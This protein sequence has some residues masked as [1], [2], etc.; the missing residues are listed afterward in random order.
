[1]HTTSRSLTLLGLSAFLA[2]GL[3]ATAQTKDIPVETVPASGPKDKTVAPAAA[4]EDMIVLSQFTVQGDKTNDY[5]AS[6]SVTGTRVASK[7]RD[8]P[9][10]VNVVTAEFMTDFGAF[11]MSQQLGWVSN[12]SPSDTQGNLVLRGFT[13][14]PFVDGF[15]RLGNLDIVDTARVEII[16]G[17]AASIYGQ[18]LPGGVVNYVSKTPSATHKDKIDLTVGSDNFFRASVSSTGPVGNSKKLFYLAS[19]STNSRNFEQQLASQQRK[20]ASMMFQYKFDEDTSVSLKINVQKDHNRDRTAIP[21]IKSSTKG[22]LTQSDGTPLKYTYTT[23]DPLTGAPSTKTANVPFPQVLVKYANNPD[24]L[25]KIAAYIAN[26][27][28]YGLNGVNLPLSNTLSTTNSWDRIGTELYQYRSDGIL[29]YNE[30]QL[31][32]LNLIGE[33]RTASWLSHRFTFDAFDR[34]YEKQSES[35][36]Q[37]YYNDPSYPDG[38]IGDATPTWRITPQKGYSSQLDNLFTFKTGPVAHKFLVT[39]DFA[40]QQKRDKSITAPNTG[41]GSNTNTDAYYLVTDSV[42][43]VQYPFNLPLGPRS[44]GILRY[45]SSTFAYTAGAQLLDGPLTD[46]NYFYPT[47]AQYPNSYNNTSLDDWRASDDYGI[48]ASE[49]ASFFNNRLTALVGG[50]YDYMVNLYKNYLGTD[51]K[52]RRSLWDDQA[53]TYQMGLTGYVT[54]NIILFANKSTAYNPNMQVVNMKQVQRDADGNE[55]PGAPVGYISQLMPN[56]AG[57]GYEYGVRFNLFQEHLNIGVSRFIVDRTNKIDSFTNEYGLSEY[58][59]N[60][61]QR[62]KG[63]EVDFNWAVT[64]SLQ[65]LGSYGYND[66]RYTANTLP[67]LVGTGTPQNAKTSASMAIRYQFKNTALK[68]LALMAGARY[69]SKSL[70]NVGS[71]GVISTNPYSSN[72]KPIIYNTALSNGVLPFPDLPANVAVLSANNS[73]QKLDPS[74]GKFVGGNEPTGALSPKTGAVLTNTGLNKGYTALNIP[75]GWAQYNSGTPMV[76]GTQYYVLDG[77]GTTAASYSRTTSIDDNRANVFNE[78]YTIWTFGLSYSIKT[79]TY[80]KMSHTIRLNLDNAFD[81]FYTYGNGVMGYGREY[82]VSYSLSF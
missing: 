27:T 18:T 60:G 72:F 36:N 40:H 24:D 73:I 42:S 9:F 10:Q 28:A 71:G 66:A 79:K 14:T 17:P 2:L 53:L 77:N 15:R 46:K 59:G 33:H 55:I 23:K 65:L 75:A 39:F 51:K 19:I 37:V 68:G 81:K 44:T 67:Y 16:K 62:S 31:Y 29:G 78:P 58:V 7:L 57:S 74:T 48:F 61:A 22:F 8:L 6:E 32:G 11:D 50:R 43:G 13:T 4:E 70:V 5:V 54:K 63:Y 20:S 30:S 80:K 26:P 1:M 82:K 45:N 47:Y 64:E 56:E 25:A 76:A 52:S 69:Y 12:I 41:T 38:K 35:G 21:W 3:T 34:P 49:R